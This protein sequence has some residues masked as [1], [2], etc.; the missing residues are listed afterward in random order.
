MRDV[1]FAGKTVTL[2]SHLAIGLLL[3]LIAGVAHAEYDLPYPLVVKSFGKLPVY[4]KPDK[5]SK[6]IGLL[7]REKAFRIG[8]G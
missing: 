3:I 1:N 5:N 8:G 7:S 4:E 6:Q 2:F